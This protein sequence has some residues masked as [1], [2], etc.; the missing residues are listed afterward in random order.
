MEVVE[1]NIEGVKLIRPRI[2]EDERGAFVETYSRGR[3]LEAGIDVEFVQD[4]LVLSR[5]KGTM[6]GL[7]F[8]SPPHAQAKLVWVVRGAIFDVAVDLRRAS[9]TFGKH[10]ALE[11]MAETS[12]QVFIP[13]G[14]AHGYCTLEDDTEV[15]YKVSA[16]YAPDHEGGVMWNDPELE[17]P[18]PVTGEE[19]IVNERDNRFPRLNEL[20]EIF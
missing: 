3:Y 14:F 19:A 5:P 10:H 7:H 16:P 6:R 12:E 15:A 17:I 20:P 1:T 9:P 2:F 13:A 4:N 11:L 18:W 8:Q